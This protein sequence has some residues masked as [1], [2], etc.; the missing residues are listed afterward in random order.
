MRV[1]FD[2]ENKNFFFS[3]NGGEKEARHFY[4]DIK[5]TLEIYMDLTASLVVWTNYKNGNESK[6]ETAMKQKMREYL[7]TIGLLG[8]K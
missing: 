6:E 4:I 5:E 3:V 2:P 7:K 8:D 1:S